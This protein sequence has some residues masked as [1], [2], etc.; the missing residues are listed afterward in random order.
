MQFSG[1]KLF[2]ESVGLASVYID[3]CAWNRKSDD[4]KHNRIRQE[5]KAVDNIIHL[6]LNKEVR[7]IFS[8]PLEKEMIKHPE[9]ARG[10]AQ[11][12]SQF[13]RNNPQIQQRS[14]QLQKK[15]LGQ[16]DSLHIACAET[17]GADVLLTTD[18]QMIRKAAQA[19]THVR[20]ANP[21]EWL[22]KSGFGRRASA[23]VA[24]GSNQLRP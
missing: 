10:A 24:S 5:T 13:V 15:G 11:V 4:Q 9:I 22:K 18:D 20:L 1:F 8:E 12:A 6:I 17:S 21:V 19:G 23:L 16:Y 7:L 3:S 14:E 2:I